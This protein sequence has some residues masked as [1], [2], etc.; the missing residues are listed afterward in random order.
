MATSAAVL[1]LSKLQDIED[2]RRVF[3]DEKRNGRMS[4]CRLGG[5]SAARG[6][7][8]GALLRFLEERRVGTEHAGGGLHTIVLDWSTVEACSADGFASFSVI[9]RALSGAGYKIVICAPTDGDLSQVLDRSG[10]RA[11]CGHLTWIPCP[12]SQPGRLEL[13][14]PAAVFGGSE[15]RGS[16]DDFLW[17]LDD[18]L[19][20]VRLERNRADLVAGAATELVQNV[21]SHAGGAEAAIVAVLHRRRRPRVLEIGVA[22]GG[23]G[24]AGHL[25][26]QDRYDRLMP[27]T[28]ALVAG[29]VFSR[30]LSGR[31]IEGGGGGLSRIVRRLR[32]KC[33]ATVL[34]RSGAALLSLSGPSTTRC[35]AH[36]LTCGWGTQVLI[37]VP[38]HS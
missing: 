21:F 13:M 19:D 30:S 35:D 10:I 7:T 5:L 3:P 33:D 22:D 34:V 38:V 26:S 6:P 36:R 25:L 2:L 18:A 32:D 31:T 24:I 28:D 9:V 11:T 16:V 29:A 1:D 20:R 37:S 23:I 14:S 27:F 12:C 17:H 4:W 8:H 15:G